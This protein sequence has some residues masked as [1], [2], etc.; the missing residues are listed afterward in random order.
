MLR[1]FFAYYR[2]YKGL[3]ILD[4]S[5]AAVVALLELGFPLAVNQVVDK[6]LIMSGRA[7]RFSGHS[8]P[9]FVTRKK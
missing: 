1:R 2:P 8:A 9:V 7:S 5:C 4:F 6:H 3:F